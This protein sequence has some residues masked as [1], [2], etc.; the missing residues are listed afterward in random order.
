MIKI[1]IIEDDALIAQ[2]YRMKFE[3]EG[4]DVDVAATGISGIDMVEARRPDLLLLD[5]TLPD[6]NGEEVLKKIRKI[7]EMLTMPVVVLT[8]IDSE[9]APKSLARWDID[10]YIVKANFTPREVV[11]KVKDVMKKRGM[12]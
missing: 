6:I 7:P 12:Q 2:M 5:L 1:A 8:N 9:S 3:V 11:A 10:E 4:F